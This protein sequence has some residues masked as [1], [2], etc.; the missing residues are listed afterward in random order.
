VR[1]LM[2]NAMAEATAALIANR[3]VLNALAEQ[4]LESETLNEAELAVLF[5]KIKKAPAR[6]GWSS[7][8]WSTQTTRPRATK[9]P[10]PRKTEPKD[11][12]A[13]ESVG[14]TV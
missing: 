10:A 1:T 6:K 11:I 2:D 9:A 14:D 3:K 12:L 13:A 5:T 8:D 7:G 4:L